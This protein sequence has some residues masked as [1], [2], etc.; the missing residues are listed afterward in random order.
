MKS[1]R[2]EKWVM[3]GAALLFGVCTASTVHALDNSP[4][5]M[6]TLMHAK[7]HHF[8]L[9]DDGMREVNFS[10]TRY[11]DICVKPQRRHPSLADE[12]SEGSTE[13]APAKPVPIAIT[14]D[15]NHATV[16]PGHCLGVEARHVSLRPASDLERSAQN[17][18]L[19][20]YEDPDLHG[21]IVR[22]PQLG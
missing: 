12:V 22:P 14:Y 17:V 19:T 1:L 18:P 15:G 9:F 11:V 4:L 13:I 7:P 20:H 6:L 16:E 10:S 3:A 5:D 21:A 2:L 8:V